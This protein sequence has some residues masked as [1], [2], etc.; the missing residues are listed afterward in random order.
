MSDLIL[1]GTGEAQRLPDG[2]MFDP[3]SGWTVTRR[4]RGSKA[5]IDDLAVTEALLGNRIVITPPDDG[6]LFILESAFADI[7]AQPADLPLSDTWEL[8]A[9]TLEKELWNL[10]FMRVEFDSIKDNRQGNPTGDPR[11]S[12]GSCINWIRR[13]IEAFISGQEKIVTLDPE[14]RPL[15]YAELHQ[16]CLAYGLHEAAFLKIVH[17]YAQGVKAFPVP[18]YVLKRTRVVAN[19]YSRSN[20]TDIYNDIFKRRTTSSLEAAEAIPNTIRFVIPQGEWVKQPPTM[21]QSS[22]TKW[23]LS[24]EWWH[25][26][27][28]EPE[29]YGELI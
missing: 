24:E 20:L 6:G 3:R 22:P 2:R 29:I 28:W 26:D 16:D 18:Q 19:N 17:L 23:T 14:E 11:L 9:N 4:W 27:K 25:A 12:S 1:T 15:T 10:P 13:A 8:D 21:K 5:K 7:E